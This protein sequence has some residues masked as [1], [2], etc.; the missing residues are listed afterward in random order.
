MNLPVFV[1][2]A[3][4]TGDRLTEVIQSP[5][6]WLIRHFALGPYGTNIEQAARQWSA[7]L[8]VEDKSKLTM[9]ATPEEALLAARSVEAE[10][11]LPLFWTCAVYFRENQ[12]FFE[13]PDTLPFLV[14]ETM[15]LDE[16]QL[17][18]R[19]GADEFVAGMRVAS[20]LSPA[21]LLKDAGVTVIAANS[22]AAA[23]LMCANGEVDACITTESARRIHGLQQVHSFGS[24]PMVFFGGTT[25]HGIAVLGG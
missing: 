12:L 17:A 3:V 19:P 24:P 18:M 16:M 4:P 14:A 6:I 15:N 11:V 2:T 8:E 10:G 21:P 23:A 22:N 5:G 1:S 9:H 25:P 20:H 7:R 13:N